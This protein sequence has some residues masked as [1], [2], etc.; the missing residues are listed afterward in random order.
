VKGREQSPASIGFSM[1]LV[2]LGHV[3]GSICDSILH[4]LQLSM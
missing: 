3:V 2:R 4:F 1:C